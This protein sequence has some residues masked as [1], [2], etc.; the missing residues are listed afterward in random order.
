MSEKMITLYKISDIIKSY[1]SIVAR[2]FLE[3]DDF[4]D[5]QLRSF[6]ADNSALL[7]KILTIVPELKDEYYLKKEQ[8]ERLLDFLKNCYGDK[9]ITLVQAEQLS[10]YIFAVG[11]GTLLWNQL[12]DLKSQ[13]E[14]QNYIRDFITKNCWLLINSPGL[15]KRVS[16][17]IDAIVEDKMGKMLN[18]FEEIHQASAIF[19]AFQLQKAQGKN[20]GQRRKQG[21]SKRKQKKEDRSKWFEQLEL[22]IQEEQHSN[23]A[24][25]LLQ[26]EII[27]NFYEKH[28]NEL[29]TLFLSEKQ[30]SSL[31]R[32]RKI[33][34][35][36]ARKTTLH[37]MPS[38]PPYL[39][40]IVNR[41][42]LDPVA[43]EEL[44]QQSLSVEMPLS[45][46][47]AEDA[48]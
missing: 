41:W 24:T 46:K 3:P 13:P 6:M 47:Q 12:E 33:D 4:Q 20:H 43:L 39:A 18:L 44:E 45:Q 10:R 11:T 32:R 5:L 34:T 37:L 29:Q 36:R 42:L 40:N 15:L 23:K 38:L 1:E 25:K 9:S 35:N 26:K 14:I 7:R 19:Y 8:K 30:F 22:E 27:L 16:N 2:I 31:F 21:S 17:A 28:Q 48:T